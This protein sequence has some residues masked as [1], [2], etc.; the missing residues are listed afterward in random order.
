[1][2]KLRATRRKAV[3]CSGPSKSANMGCTLDG[4]SSAVKDVIEI[5]RSVYLWNSLR[6]RSLFQR[7]HN[8]LTWPI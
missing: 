7:G 2:V 3:G 5:G 1:M 8:K 6:L 4:V